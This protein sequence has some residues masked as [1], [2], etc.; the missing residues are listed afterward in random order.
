M[1]NLRKKS[2]KLC[3]HRMRSKAG[4]WKALP[5]VRAEL[6]PLTSSLQELLF[7]HSFGFHLRKKK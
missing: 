1:E 4:T 3:R 6:P 5:F 7:I 2:A